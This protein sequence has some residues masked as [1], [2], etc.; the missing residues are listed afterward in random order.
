M[1]FLRKGKYQADVEVAQSAINEINSQGSQIRF[2]NED[3]F[4]HYTM[5]DEAYQGLLELEPEHKQ[6]AEG[7]RKKLREQVECRLL[8]A[9]RA[10]GK[11]EPDYEAALR[12]Y[13]SVLDIR[14]LL[15]N[16]RLPLT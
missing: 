9:V 6:W 3:I 16:L 2:S 8:F 5:I 7:R 10:T 14:G 13:R 4:R 12:Y 15:R 1:R 11:L